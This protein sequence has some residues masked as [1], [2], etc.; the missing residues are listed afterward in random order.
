MCASPSW[1][2][3]QPI[4]TVTHDGGHET[5]VIALSG[6]VDQT[7][8]LGVEQRLDDALG[9]EQR[10][11]VID[12]LAMTGMDAGTLVA[13]CRAVRRLRQRGGALT[14]IGAPPAVRRTL[15]LCDLDAVVKSRSTL[16]AEPQPERAQAF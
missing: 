6:V 4:E 5:R 2:L 8:V 13:F 10:R 16:A 15:E 11:F 3:A 14:V 7:T 9:R 1:E 12:L